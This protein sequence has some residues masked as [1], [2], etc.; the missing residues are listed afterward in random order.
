LDPSLRFRFIYRFRFRQIQIRDIARIYIGS[1]FWSAS[2]VSFLHATDLSLLQQIRAISFLHA[3]D[4]G[5]I[6]LACSR[7]EL[8]PSCM[9]QIRAIYF[10][11]AAD[12]SLLQQIQAISFLHATDPSL[13][14][15]I[16]ATSFLHAAN[17][18]CMCCLGR[19]RPSGTRLHHIPRS[20]AIRSQFSVGSDSCMQHSFHACS[21]FDL[22]VADQ[23][24]H[25][26]DRYSTCLPWYCR[27]VLS[28]LQSN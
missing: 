1:V 9:Q 2:S 6:L 11:H 12:P 15:Q 3:A 23:P 17:P 22:H 20:I 7:S 14:Q 21:R 18:N 27:I 10:L 28:L 19:G 8:Y 25:V 4:P 24:M 5:Y 16:R 13:L 26:I